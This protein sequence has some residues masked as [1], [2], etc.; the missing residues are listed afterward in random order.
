[1]LEGAKGRLGVVH[2]GECK[3]EFVGASGRWG[4][5]VVEGDWVLW[6]GSRSTGSRTGS[7]CF[8][9]V[10]SAGANTDLGIASRLSGEI[11]VFFH[12]P[13]MVSFENAFLRACA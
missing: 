13:R 7:A 5:G 6:M 2:D 8:V 12:A 9:I 1:M 11:P 10:F 3:V 4:G